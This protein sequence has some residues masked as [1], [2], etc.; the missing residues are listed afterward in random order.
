MPYGIEHRHPGEAVGHGTGKGKGEIDDPQHACRFRD[1]GR[2]LFL[3][4]H[5]RGLGPVQLH[6][7]DTQQRQ[8]GDSQHDDAHAA[9]P[10]DLLPVIEDGRGQPVQS[11]D[12][13]GTGRGESGDGFEYGIG[14]AEVQPQDER[15]RTDDTQYRP[16]QGHEE[17]AVAHGQLAVLVEV[18]QP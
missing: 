6:A 1:T 15:Q 8:D 4:C 10:L 13:R 17:K 18:R 3:L 12:D 16:E 5:T 14:N 9:E 7:T 11:D 2:D